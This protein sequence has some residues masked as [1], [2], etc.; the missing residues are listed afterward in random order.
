MSIMCKM[1]ESC[2]AARGMC[3]HEKI[4]LTML[5]VLVGVGVLYL[6]L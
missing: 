4:M 1:N 6:V 3:I 5:I 2:H